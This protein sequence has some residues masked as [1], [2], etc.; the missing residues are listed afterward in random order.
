MATTAN[1]IGADMA[2]I[3]DGSTLH[4]ISAQHAASST[5]SSAANSSAASH[6]TAPLHCPPCLLLSS[7]KEGERRIKRIL[8]QGPGQSGRTSM[9]MDLAYAC[10]ARSTTSGAKS[11]H[12]LLQPC[13]CTSVVFY[14]LASNAPT[15]QPLNSD[16]SRDDF[17]LSCRYTG[18]SKALL[19]TTL[20]RHGNENDD[21]WDPAILRHIR[22][23][24]VHSTR[25]L[26]EDLLGMLGKPAREHPAGAI[27][28]D[29]LDLLITQGGSRQS[30][31]SWDSQPPQHRP[32]SQYPSSEATILMM[33]ASK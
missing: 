7:Q 33:Q 15:V 24:Y 19:G 16:S 13:C 29:D 22:I 27:I 17:P 6:A 1:L 3:L 32:A 26:L 28:V 8:L 5:T 11:C 18:D 14:R 12:C 30:S 21:C 4:N 9:A 25:E 23:Q 31:S 20:M 2:Q 10:A